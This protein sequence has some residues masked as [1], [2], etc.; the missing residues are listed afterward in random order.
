M[1]AHWAIKIWTAQREGSYQEVSNLNLE[2]EHCKYFDLR[3][4]FCDQVIGSQ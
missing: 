2:H 4:G 1:Y 3:L